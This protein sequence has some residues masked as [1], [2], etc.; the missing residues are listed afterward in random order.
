MSHNALSNI[1]YHSDK[2]YLSSQHELP[3]LRSVA[4]KYGH[5]SEVVD[6]IT[7]ET[8]IDNFDKL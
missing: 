3:L 7:V 8:D 4:Y 2:E 6:S 1:L 5:A